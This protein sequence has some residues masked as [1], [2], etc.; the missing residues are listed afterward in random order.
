MPL[1]LLKSILKKLLPAPLL[2][3]AFLVYNTIRIRT[4]DRLLFP[5]YKV[6]E[7][8][9]LLYRRGYPFKEEHIK[10]DDLPDGE[11]KNYM[12]DWYKWTQEEFILEFNQ[13]CIIEPDHGWAIVPRNKLLYYS[14]G[15]SRTLFQPKPRFIAFLMRKKVQSVPLAISLRDTGE[16]NYFHCFNDVLSK[17]FFLKQHGIPVE[18]IPLVVSRKLWSKPYFQYYFKCSGWFQSLKWLIQDDQ[19]I[20]CKTAI[21]CKPLTHRSDLWKEIVTPL[22][23]QPSGAATRKVFLTRN[24]ARL[25]FIENSNEIEDI[26]RALQYEIVDTDKLTP[27]QQ[28]ELFATTSH[29]VGIHGAG[30]TNMAFCPPGC[31]VLELFPPP[32][33]GYLPYH[34]ILLAKIK[35][36][37]YCALIGS[38][39]EARFS[40]GFRIDPAKFEEA[41]RWMNS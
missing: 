39:P 5:E 19:Y 21:F 8:K 15:V 41:L 23:P 18:K 40:G 14:L 35:A 13:P 28:I 16:E 33:L 2:K 12:E 38:S 29:L 26:C 31:R 11:V 3:Q 7:D 17:I 25:R 9:F 30:L 32:D 20:Q 24:K 10:I 4:I 36:F 6:P 37:S 34:Y 27:S 1:K 22:M